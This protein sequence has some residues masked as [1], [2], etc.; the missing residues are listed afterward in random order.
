MPKPYPRFNEPAFLPHT[1]ATLASEC[2]PNRRIEELAGFI[3]ANTQRLFGL[4]EL[5]YDGT[6]GSRGVVLD[7]VGSISVSFARFLV[8]VG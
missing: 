6:F 7:W 3:R 8:V 5:P 1:L 2:F 4:P